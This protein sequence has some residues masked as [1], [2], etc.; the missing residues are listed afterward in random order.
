MITGLSLA[1]S[2]RCGYLGQRNVPAGLSLTE[3]HDCRFHHTIPNNVQFKTY[4]LLISETFYLVFSDHRWPHV[5]ET[6]ETE[7][8][9]RTIV[10]CVETDSVKICGLNW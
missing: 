9:G 7:T 10:L 2:V 8:K 6:K 5:I 4:E 1:G 3:P